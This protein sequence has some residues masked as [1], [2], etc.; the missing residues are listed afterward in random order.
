MIAW[1]LLTPQRLHDAQV[2]VGD[3]ATL[4]KGQAQNVK[5]CFGPPGSNSRMR[6]PSAELVD[7]G[8][9]FGSDDRMPIGMISTVVPICTRLVTPARY[10]STVSAS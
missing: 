5:L 10:A 8:D 6:R 4:G 9:G 7:A 3:P 1:R 2:F